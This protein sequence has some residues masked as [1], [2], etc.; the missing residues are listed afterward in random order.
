M[1]S[2][3]LT[4]VVNYLIFLSLTVFNGIADAMHVLLSHNLGAG[5]ARRIRNSWAARFA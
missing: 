3:G 4:G 2:Q 5:N 1:T